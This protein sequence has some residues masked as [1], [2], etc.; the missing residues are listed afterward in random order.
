MAT[1]PVTS[2]CLK[3]QLLPLLT[4]RLCCLNATP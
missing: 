3:L 4:S 1:L 2:V